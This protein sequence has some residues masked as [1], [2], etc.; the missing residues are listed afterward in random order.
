MNDR[1]MKR[2]LD[3][4]HASADSVL[5][6]EEHLQDDEYAEDTEI[7]T[8]AQEL[9]D[10]SALRLARVT[11]EFIKEIIKRRHKTGNFQYP[12]EP[13]DEYPNAGRTSS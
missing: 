10:K 7:L 5:C 1:E 2:L 12:L 3:K 6:A 8:Q 4:M 13:F 9:K 11:S